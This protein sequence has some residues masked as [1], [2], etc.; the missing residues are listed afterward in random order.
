MSAFRGLY[1]MV[2]SDPLW[3]PTPRIFIPQL[4]ISHL[5]FEEHTPGDLKFGLELASVV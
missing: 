2:I 3:F 1:L 4:S 5:E